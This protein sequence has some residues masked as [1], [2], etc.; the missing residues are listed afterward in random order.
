MIICVCSQAAQQ[1]KLLKELRTESWELDLA[2]R[3]LF[4]PV[5]HML[6]A[7]NELVIE[8][9][10]IGIGHVKAFSSLQRGSADL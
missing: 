6:R 2:L 10:G 8:G 5:I 9:T 1:A 3:T 7:Q 4:Y